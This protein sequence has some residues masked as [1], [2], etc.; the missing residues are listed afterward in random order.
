MSDPIA[1]TG[2]PEDESSGPMRPPA[3]RVQK[4]RAEVIIN[5]EVVRQRRR[6][7]GFTQMDL[8]IMASCS[9]RTIAM[10]ERGKS[11]DPATSVTLRLARA[12]SC[13]VEALCSDARPYSSRTV[14]EPRVAPKVGL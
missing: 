14:R 9:P 13:T 7:L 1:L 3:K 2:A 11:I 6:A 8:A 5:A 10:I 12:L 4:R